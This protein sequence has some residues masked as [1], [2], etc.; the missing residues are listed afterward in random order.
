MS[1]VLKFGKHKGQPIEE[2]LAIDPQYIEWLKAKPWFQEKNPTL[3]NIVVNNVVNSAEPADTPEHNSY[4]VRFID[5]GY[6]TAFVR[7]LFPQAS[8]PFVIKTEFEVSGADVMIRVCNAAMDK[9]TQEWSLWLEDW[10]NSTKPG[11]PPQPRCPPDA[12]SK[13]L[14]VEI[15]PVVGDDY[16]AILRQIKQYMRV[17]YDWE[18]PSFILLI[19]QYCGVGATTDQMVK[20]FEA[21]GIRVAFAENIKGWEG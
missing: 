21:S 5:A 19:G 7:H 10:Y 6:T 17:L 18:Q 2:V 11:K 12:I 8:T 1:N 16:P 13:K 14:F 9:H 20:T 3:Y 4:Q 15:K